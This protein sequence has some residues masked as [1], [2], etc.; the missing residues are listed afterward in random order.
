MRWKVNKEIL[1]GDYE[2]IRAL[3]QFDNV[4]DM[5]VHIDSKLYVDKEELSETAYEV[6]QFIRKFIYKNRSGIGVCTAKR[7]TIAAK[8]GRSVKSV[9]RAIKQLFELGFIAE[10]FQTWDKAEKR[11]GHLVLAV[12]KLKDL[13]L[14]PWKKKGVPPV[15]PAEMSLREN[16]EIPCESKDEGSKN[17]AETISFTSYYSKDFKKQYNSKDVQE[18]IQQ[19]LTLTKED[20]PDYVPSEFADHVWHRGLKDIEAITDYWHSAVYSYLQVNNLKHHSELSLWQIE[21]IAEEAIEAFNITNRNKNKGFAKSKNDSWF[22]KFG[23]FFFGVMKNR[24]ADIK[25]QHEPIAAQKEDEP[26]VIQPVH[27]KEIWEE[28]G[29]ER[30]EF[31]GTKEEQDALGVF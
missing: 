1:A 28:M 14:E 20:I 18:N 11:A 30:E 5:D 15:V 22:K 10:P 27:K 23:G 4:K 21:Q 3:S 24:I 12:Q 17:D 8:I 31:Y 2:V 13:V 19:E 29:M 9:S 6:L 16:E 25:K 26:T 7:E